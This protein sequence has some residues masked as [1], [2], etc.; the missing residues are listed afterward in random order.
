MGH[1]SL[2][3]SDKEQYIIDT[4]F[5][6]RPGPNFKNLSDLVDS[7]ENSPYIDDNGEVEVFRSVNKSKPSSKVR[8]Q[9]R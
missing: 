3:N 7:Y 2:K 5:I 9:K 6:E 8:K 4:Y 1:L